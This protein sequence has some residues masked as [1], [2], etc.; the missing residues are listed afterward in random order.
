M[1]HSYSIITLLTLLLNTA[2][3]AHAFTY[4]TPQGKKNIEAGG[5]QI[6]KMP[7]EATAIDLRGVAQ[8]NT[9]YT[10]DR[11]DA[12]PNCLYYLDK[13]DY[14]ENLPSH[15]VVRNGTANSLIISDQDDYFCPIPFTAN[16]ALFV[17]TPTPHSPSTLHIETL[18]LPFQ[19]DYAAPASVNFFDD[20]TWV[21]VA[22]CHEA[23]N[24][25]FIFTPN[26][27]HS[28][29]PYTPYLIAFP[30]EVDDSRMLF[31]AQNKQ[32]PQTQDARIGFHPYYFFGT[33]YALKP[34]F[35]CY[36]L[37]PDRSDRFVLM[38]SEEATRPFR[39]YIINTDINGSPSHE[40]TSSDDTIPFN[41]T[42]DIEAPTNINHLPST[43][44]RQPSSILHQP[45]Y[46]L[47]GQP[48][49]QL[50]RGINIVNHKKILV[51]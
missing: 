1:K 4:W 46:S 10:L 27:L 8:I 45:S 37:D 30:P 34:V 51:K 33:T 47:S 48:Q 17:M 42:F 2:A 49:K 15:N 28:M 25:F 36:Q 39:C 12:N 7:H 22:Q 13:N 41:A 3:T 43:V 14:V 31:F 29:L 19:P 16:D 26:N 5:F 35:G 18:L 38:S 50:Q 20:D 24:G 9:I 21:K 44:N 11:E 32:I 6:I 23:Q 40:A